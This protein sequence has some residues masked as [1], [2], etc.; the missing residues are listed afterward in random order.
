MKKYNAPEIELIVLQSSDCMSFDSGTYGIQ[1]DEL[2]FG[3]FFGEQ[4]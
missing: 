2:D 3:Q 4:E 1:M